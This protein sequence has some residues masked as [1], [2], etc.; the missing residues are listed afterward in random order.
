MEQKYTFLVE[1]QFH[2]Y[3]K[4]KF[5]FAIKEIKIAI[6][7]EGGIWLE[8]GGA[9]SRPANIERDIEK[10]NLAQEQ[11]WTVIRVHSKT[12]KTVLQLLKKQI[13][14]QYHGDNK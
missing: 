5:D 1:H 6:E 13:N 4:F 7:Y 14:Q 2:L 8:G 3:R 10:Y 9:H 11:G 12:H